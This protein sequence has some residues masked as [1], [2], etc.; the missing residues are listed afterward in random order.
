L[1]YLLNQS[2]I[3]T[4]F[5]VKAKGPPPPTE[6]V[7]SGPG[8]KKGSTNSSSGA[9]IDVEL[10]EDELAMRGEEEEE[11]EDDENHSPSMTHVTTLTRQPSCIN[12]N[13]RYPSLSFSLAPPLPF[14]ILISSHR[15]YQLEGLNWLIR[16]TENGINGILA[17]EMGLGML[18]STYPP[19]LTHSPSLLPAQEKPYKVSR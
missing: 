19:V 5:G 11:E 15:P 9:G 1:K 13:M 18:H 8:R 10:D 4:H 7:K 6:P 17:D 16:L 12:G 2:D 14:T 3:F